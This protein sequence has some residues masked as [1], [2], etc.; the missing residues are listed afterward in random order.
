M[1]HSMRQ[2]YVP[3]RRSAAAADRFRLRM[4]PINHHVTRPL[5]SPNEI[6]LSV[7]HP[8]SPPLDCDCQPLANHLHLPSLLFPLSPL[9]HLRLQTDGW[10]N[11]SNMGVLMLTHYNDIFE[12][13][14]QF[15]TCQ[16]EK[17]SLHHASQGSTFGA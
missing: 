10:T 15:V 2:H 1:R 11:Y 4:G 9:C 14:L 13:Q 3:A 6:Q 5:H 17:Y 16:V 7:T 8:L 12:S